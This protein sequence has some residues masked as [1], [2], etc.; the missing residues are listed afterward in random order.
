V[1]TFY[2]ESEQHVVDIEVGIIPHMK[3]VVVAKC[4]GYISLFFLT[5]SC[6]TV[7]NT[8]LHIGRVSFNPIQSVSIPKFL[9]IGSNFIGI[10]GTRT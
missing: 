8:M 6:R 1:N 4:Y 10:S 5:E 7:G 2:L 9:R 3:E